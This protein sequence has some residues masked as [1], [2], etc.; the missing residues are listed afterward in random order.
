MRHYHVLIPL[1]YSGKETAE[2]GAQYIIDV[3]VVCIHKLIFT[4]SAASQSISKSAA[5]FIH[6]SFARR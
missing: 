6:S 4:R 3:Y 2:L 1:L 5:S